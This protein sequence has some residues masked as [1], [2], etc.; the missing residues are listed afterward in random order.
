MKNRYIE[1]TEIPLTGNDQIIITGTWREKKPVVINELCRKCRKCIDFCPDIAISPGED[2][3]EINYD[4]CKGCGICRNVCPH[5][6]IK[7]EEE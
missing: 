2:S 4:F 1:I 3:V 6:A 7:M 5:D